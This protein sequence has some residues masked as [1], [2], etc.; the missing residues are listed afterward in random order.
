MS[1]L[2]EQI[3]AAIELA[4]ERY[5]DDDT[6]IDDEPATSVA[7]TGIWVAAWVWV[8]NSDIWTRAEGG[9]GD[10]ERDAAGDSQAAG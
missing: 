2:P 9:E 10:D 5:C 4:R 3:E 8:P 1:A 7:E 6:E